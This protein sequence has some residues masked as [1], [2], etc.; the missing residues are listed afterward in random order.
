MTY[1]LTLRLKASCIN[2]SGNDR[3]QPT[4]TGEWTL[5]DVLNSKVEGT[6][7]QELVNHRHGQPTYADLKV[8]ASNLE[9]GIT[10]LLM[11]NGVG[12]DYTEG[13]RRVVFTQQQRPRLNNGRERIRIL[14]G[15][16]KVQAEY[17]LPKGCDLLPPAPPAKLPVVVPPV[18]RPSIPA[19]A[20]FGE[21]EQLASPGAGVQ[22][23]FPDAVR[24]PL[25][26]QP[27]SMD[28]ERVTLDLSPLNGQNN[29]AVA[30]SL[31]WGSP[32]TLTEAGVLLP[33]RLPS[34]PLPSSLERRVRAIVPVTATV[35]LRWTLG[36]DHAQ[37]F[38]LNPRIDAHEQRGIPH[39]YVARHPTEHVNAI[40]TYPPHY[41]LFD[42]RSLEGQYHLVHSAAT[43]VA[44]YLIWQVTGR[45]LGPEASH[46]PVLI[47]AQ[48]GQSD[49]WCRS[50]RPMSQCCG[51]RGAA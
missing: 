8:L 19:A 35:E 36:L 12:T 24:E 1:P 30:R 31:A 4:P 50:G 47:M 44:N 3:K 33:E 26:I 16:G 13:S 7:I 45:W 18:V 2:P 41:R 39:L 49:C 10:E 9:P 48:Y 21:V 38:C 17:D 51:R 29:V 42:P 25:N 11:Y 14:D 20:A 28:I 22:V 5:F 23:F 43:W 37:V 15:S 46:S 32:M 6:R 40:C 34:K 27:G